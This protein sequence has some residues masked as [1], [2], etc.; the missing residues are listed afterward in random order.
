VVLEIARRVLLRF[1]LIRS[2]N[3]SVV[4]FRGK[5]CWNR[6]KNR[7]MLS[8]KS[9]QSP[10]KFTAYKKLLKDPSSCS[11]VVAFRLSSVR[12][13]LLQLRE[14]N[15]RALKSAKNHKKSHIKSSNS[16]FSRQP[17]FMHKI[18]FTD[19]WPGLFRG[20]LK[21]V[22]CCLPIPFFAV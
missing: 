4:G 21:V 22:L 16:S 2:E 3:H 5:K 14:R 6:V 9:D 20:S 18:W 8:P 1:G 17:K 7:Q 15:S 12:R 10:V 19:L 13:E 11:F